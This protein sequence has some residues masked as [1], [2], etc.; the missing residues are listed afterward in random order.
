[1]S[2]ILILVGLAV[3]WPLAYVYGADSRLQSDRGLVRR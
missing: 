2:A 1:M 3:L